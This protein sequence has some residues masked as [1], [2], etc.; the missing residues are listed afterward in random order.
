MLEERSAK[1]RLARGA[2]LR[3]LRSVASP[4]EAEK[5][6]AGALVVPSSEALLRRALLKGRQARSSRRKA[7]LLHPRQ[8]SSAMAAS[9]MSR[10]G[11]SSQPATAIKHPAPPPP[12]PDEVLPA[13]MV[14]AAGAD[15]TLSS[16]EESTALST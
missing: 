16:L 1:E 5:F 14:T 4:L 9:G 11:E 3:T 15:L 10:S 2:A 12:P 13:L 8:I 6:T 7:P